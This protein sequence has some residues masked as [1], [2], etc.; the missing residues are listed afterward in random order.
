MHKCS[1]CGFNS[2]KHYWQCPSCH[3]WS[4]IK[5]NIKINIKLTIMSYKNDNT[6]RIIV[7][8]DCDN[9]NALSIIRKA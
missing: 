1:N 3:Q 9:E 4:T 7:A 5:N 8:I 2:I 6:P